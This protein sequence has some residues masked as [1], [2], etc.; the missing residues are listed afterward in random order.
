MITIGTAASANSGGG[1]TSDPIG[2]TLTF[3]TGEDLSSGC[4]GTNKL[5]ATV[6]SFAAN[7]T[8]VFMNGVAQRRGIDNDYIEVG[9]TAIEMNSAPKSTFEL[10]INY[11]ILS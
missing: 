9:N 11:T 6:N 7:T 1:L 2:T 8:A 10:I 4:N 5:F 3:V